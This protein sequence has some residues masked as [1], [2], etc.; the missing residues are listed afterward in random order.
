MS[1]CPK[2]DRF[3]ENN[4]SIY[5]I[6]IIRYIIDGGIG[7]GNAYQRIMHRESEE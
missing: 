1:N 6:S 3:I 2:F 4:N 5:G 7:S